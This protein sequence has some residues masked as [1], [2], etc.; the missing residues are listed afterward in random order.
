MQWKGFIT[1]ALVGGL[2]VG[3][4][5]FLSDIASLFIQGPKVT[6][7]VLE[8]GVIKQENAV[9]LKMTQ[10]DWVG[11][12]AED[13]MGRLSER[14]LAPTA[15]GSDGIAA[16][17]IYLKLADGQVVEIKAHCAHAEPTECASQGV[18]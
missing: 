10:A 4:I 6:E 15:K 7:L 16:G 9:L 5:Y 12:T 14:G 11:L 13:A 17:Q 2:T 3:S 18:N 8:N 1:G